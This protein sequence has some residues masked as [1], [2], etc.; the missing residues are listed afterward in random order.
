MGTPHPAGQQRKRQ[1]PFIPEIEHFPLQRRGKVGLTGGIKPFCAA[2]RLAHRGAQ[3]GI[4]RG[5]RSGM[6]LRAHQPVRAADRNAGRLG[7]RVTAGADLEP[8]HAIGKP[9]VHPGKKRIRGH[10]VQI[11]AGQPGHAGQHNHA[12]KQHE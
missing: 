12:H 6:V 10:A 11:Q 7:G 1:L 2:E 8:A 9:L 4:Q 5:H 3:H